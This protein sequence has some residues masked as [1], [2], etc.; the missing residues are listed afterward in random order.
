MPKGWRGA[1]S[2]LPLF[3]VGHSSR[4]SGV[5]PSAPAFV[6]TIRWQEPATGAWT[7]RDPLGDVDGLNLYSFVSGNPPNRMD[8]T[9]LSA[10][11]KPSSPGSRE[12]EP[13]Q[14]EE[15]NCPCGP[16]D[17][18]AVQAEMASTCTTWRHQD[19]AALA[20]VDPSVRNAM[21]RICVDHGWNPGAISYGGCVPCRPGVC[22]FNLLNFGSPGA[23]YFCCLN[24]SNSEDGAR[25][26]PECS[27]GGCMDIIRHEVMHSVCLSF[28]GPTS[29]CKQHKADLD[30][31]YDAFLRLAHDPRDSLAELTLATCVSVW[32][33]P[34]HPR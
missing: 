31:C 29:W 10:E 18:G 6:G 8:P 3:F 14:D 11:D 12:A 21:D 9:G 24:A 4:R 2:I 7:A 19:P 32:E 30:S 34:G 22:A 27:G 33:P 26:R 20:Q 23:I 5:R 13:G 28:G 16:E 15:C 25:Y 1:L 17:V